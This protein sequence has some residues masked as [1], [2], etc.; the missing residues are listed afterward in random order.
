MSAFR[1]GLNATAEYEFLQ[2]VTVTLHLRFRLPEQAAATCG[3]GYSNFGY[4]FLTTASG[5][6]PAGTS[7]GRPA[8]TIGVDLEISIPDSAIR[9]QLSRRH[10]V[11]SVTTA[12]L[13][14]W[15]RTENKVLSML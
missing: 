6:L 11:M 8:E 7:S 2:N 3:G 9:L 15:T 12:S 5:L 13:G 14:K 4:F 10:W 1:S